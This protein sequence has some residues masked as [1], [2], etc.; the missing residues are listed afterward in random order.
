MVNKTREIPFR[1]MTSCTLG[2]KKK[3]KVMTGCTRQRNV[4][5]CADLLLNA[6]VIFRQVGGNKPFPGRRI[7][8]VQCC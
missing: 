4:C 7:G 3:K 2:K 1:M 6:A 8:D 5:V